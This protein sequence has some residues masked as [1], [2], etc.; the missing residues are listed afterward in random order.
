MKVK[1]ILPKVANDVKEIRKALKQFVLWSKAVSENDCIKMLLGSTCLVESLIWFYIFFIWM[2]DVV[3]RFCSKYSS[4]SNLKLLIFFPFVFFDVSFLNNVKFMYHL[5]N[6]I[7]IRK[8]IIFLWN[9]HQIPK[10]NWI[11]QPWNGCKLRLLRNAKKLLMYI[12]VYIL[13]FRVC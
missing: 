8:N 9:F 2:N 6:A 13:F 5:K 7:T 1:K 10:I 4:L 3:I 11:N 12:A